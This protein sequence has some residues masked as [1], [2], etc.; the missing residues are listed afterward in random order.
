MQVAA[1]DVVGV[2]GVVVG[3]IEVVLCDVVFGFPRATSATSASAT[4]SGAADLFGVAG[5][6][7]YAFPL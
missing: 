6:N 7:V 1:A 3:V 4:G 2:L 5:G